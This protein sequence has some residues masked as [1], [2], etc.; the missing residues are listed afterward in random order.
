MQ[1]LMSKLT[2][3]N[4]IEWYRSDAD[5]DSVKDLFW[6]H[7]FA[8]DLLRAFPHVLIMDCTYKT[9]RYAFPLLEVVG[10][11]STEMTFSVCFAYIEREREDNYSWALDKL[12]GFM[13]NNMLPSVIV[14]DREVALMNAIQNVFPTATHLL[15][16]WHISK[17]ILANCK[18]L[19]ETNE[20]W[21]SFI[22]SWNILVL[23]ATKDHYMQHLRLLESEFVRYQEAIDY[24][25]NTWLTKY[26]EKFIAA[27]TDSI[28]H[29]GNTTSNRVETSHSALKRQLQSSR[30]TFE[31]LW[32]KIHALV[33][34]Q[35][36][37]IK[38]SLERSSTT[39]QHDFKPSVFKE[40]RGFV[41]RNALNMIFCESKRADY[42]GLDP[43][44]CGCVVRHTHGIPCAHEI[45]RYKREGRPIPLSSINL[46]WKKLDL[47]P[48]TKAETTYLS[49]STEMEMILQ[50]FNNNDYTG[51]LKILKKL[52]E[53]ANP[54]STYLI[55]PEAKARARGRPSSKADNST[56]RDLSKFEHVLSALNS[57]SPH[58]SSSKISIQSKL[59]QRK[60]VHQSQLPKHSSFINSFP[61]GLRPYIHHVKDVAA[62]GNCGFR[63]VADLIGLGED[64]WIQVRRDLIDELKSHFDD[65][66]QIFKYAGRSDEILQSLSYFESNPSND[67]WMTFPEAGYLIAS[68]YNVVLIFLSQ[69]QCL[70]F[71][72]LRSTPLPRPSQKIIAIGFIHNCHF[73]QVFMNPGS[74]M[75]PIAS[76]WLKYHSSVAEGWATPYD[77]NI[78]AFK[79][80]VPNVASKDTIDLDDQ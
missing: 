56:R 11:T 58:L 23:S 40:L 54:A 12:K 26:K 25:K 13:D 60:K 29:L 34:L 57:H 6:A 41:S 35:H 4:Y 37:E 70:T 76:S 67:Y 49:C 43:L 39:V 42:I 32:T 1:L 45:A 77:R 5:T 62:D 71:L 30:G 52:K 38:A 14:T 17:N 10:V 51:K 31:T 73:I 16:R 20:V 78:I 72:P 44:A 64:N 74:P 3:H 2:E 27:W 19:F 33:E 68:K 63:V 21:E 7:P 28:M 15:C 53:L 50:R 61:Q 69:L 18:K 47:L 75:P 79:D 66:T 80:L 55:E 22:T 9:N 65:Y 46:H 48:T 59:R 36:T 8:I 24:V